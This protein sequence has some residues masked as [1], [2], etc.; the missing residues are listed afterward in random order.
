MPRKNFNIIEWYQ[1][2]QPEL[3]KRWLKLLEKEYDSGNQVG[4]KTMYYTLKARADGD[5][6]KYPTR[7]FIEDFLNRQKSYQVNKRTT[8]KSDTISSIIAHR[9]NSIIQFDYMYMYWSTD[10][11][12]APRKEGPIDTE[13]IRDAD[14]KWEKE[15][16]NDYKKLTKEVNNKFNSKKIKYR[17]ALMAIDGFSRYAYAVPIPGNINSHEATKAM[18]KILDESK[19]VWGKDAKWRTVMTDK[20]SEFMNEFREKMKSLNQTTRDD[21]GKR[22]TY[23]KHSFGYSG[24]SQS[25]GLVER[26]N[27]TIKKM[28]VKALGGDF[29]KKWWELLPIVIGA[30]NSNYHST[31]GRSPKSVVDAT[32]EELKE[33]KKRILSKAVRQ[34]RIDRGAF[35]PGEYV[36]IKVEKA[37]KLDAKFTTKGGLEVLA[38]KRGVDDPEDFAGVFMVDGVKLAN[39]GDDERGRVAHATT[40]RIVANWNKESKVQSV[41]SGQLKARKGYRVKIKH[42]RV[43]IGDLYPA[44]AYARHFTKHQLV[45]VPADAKGLPVVEESADPLDKEKRYEVLEIIRKG[46]KGT[47]N[48]GKYLTR[49]EGYKAPE[50]AEYDDIKDTAAFEEWEKKNT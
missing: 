46:R 18:M 1:E 49:Y 41:P 9:P 10:G 8:S 36:R 7:R 30:Y 40:Y 31:I 17:G 29:S 39:A 4:L 28:L 24:R 20:G 45:R 43:L 34:H 25:Q 27:G 21:K 32:E 13:G 2:T 22:H 37:G 23:Y 6:S 35:K 11:G 50:W 38:K 12:F 42:N 5:K 16:T 48:E 14:G 33:I 19:K 3:A 15:P 47:K 26:L 44:A